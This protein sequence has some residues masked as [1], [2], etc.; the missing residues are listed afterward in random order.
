M[1]KK[2]E[3]SAASAESK[4][5]VFNFS[6][7]ILDVKLYRDPDS[8]LVYIG[9]DLISKSCNGFK[10]LPLNLQQHTTNPHDDE[11]KILKK[12]WDNAS[13]ENTT[14][15]SSNY[16]LGSVLD[17]TAQIEIPKSSIYYQ[18]PTNPDAALN[19]LGA[20]V[21][22]LNQD[23]KT[24]CMHFHDH[25]KDKDDSLFYQGVS[26][27]ENIG[28]YQK[29][30][31]VSR[32]IHKILIEAL[33]SLKQ[34]H[35]SDCYSDTI[36]AIETVYQKYC[37]DRAQSRNLNFV[38]Y[39]NPVIYVQ[40]RNEQAVKKLVDSVIGKPAHD[41]GRYK[42][43]Y[44]EFDFLR[45]A[46]FSITEDGKLSITDL[47]KNPIYL[48]LYAPGKR[49][50]HIFEPELLFLANKMGLE[51]DKDNFK[52]NGLVFNAESTQILIEKFGIVWTKETKQ[53]VTNDKYTQHSGTFFSTNNTNKPNTNLSIH[54]HPDNI[55]EVKA[56]MAIGLQL[57]EQ[58]KNQ[59]RKV[60]NC[61]QM[62][63]L[64]NGIDSVTAKLDLNTNHVT[65]IFFNGR[66]G[67]AD[68]KVDGENKA[69]IKLLKELDAK[70][71]KVPYEHSYWSQ[72]LV[73]LPYNKIDSVIK[74]LE[75]L[76]DKICEP[77]MLARC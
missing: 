29:E 36:M 33:I 68:N 17:Q 1:Q 73:T 74:A 8:Q 27:L 38:A 70:D 15:L 13:K 21:V 48:E 50:E 34:D 53:D 4:K 66:H 63:Q 67:T 28:H 20:F 47:D 16:I 6:K 44:T 42:S 60:R 54:E 58:T 46:S 43:N 10:K 18:L 62:I 55:Y 52:E 69:I 61:I 35:S 7:N 5:P 26:K 22:Y 51:F 57:P 59:L 71:S 12:V 41:G 24:F 19:F 49:N 31:D 25:S 14:F 45:A 11:E 30:N 2:M 65:F 39:V 56:N 72:S 23:T 76:E 77:K 37:D 32:S 64:K 3:F 40:F 9:F 75:L